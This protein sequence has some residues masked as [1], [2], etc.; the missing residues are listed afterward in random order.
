M[1]NKCKIILKINLVVT[2]ILFIFVLLMM[3][4]QRAAPNKSGE[5]TPPYMNIFY[6]GSKKSRTNKGTA[7][8]SIY[9][10]KLL[11]KI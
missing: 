10:I 3:I 7:L 4:N 11:T 9:Q 8:F 1:Q 2:F 5:Y 6:I